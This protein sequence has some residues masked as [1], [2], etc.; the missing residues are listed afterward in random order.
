[1]PEC[2]YR[3]S[4]K[5][6]IYDEN[7]KILLC[8][9]ESWNW[10]FPGWWLDHWEDYQACLKRELFEEMWLKV[11]EIS[12]N[13]SFF[14]TANKS[15]SQFRPWTVNIFYEIKVQNIDFTKSNECIEIWFFNPDEIWK[16]QWNPN[17]KE[18]SKLF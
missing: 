15:E 10:D 14:I 11:K 13:P 3:V 12:D 9:E 5:A 6:L 4:I 7:K 8:K 1:M 18:F 17:L 2:Q 16:L